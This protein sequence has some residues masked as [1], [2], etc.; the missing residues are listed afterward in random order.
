MRRCRICRADLTCGL[1]CR[2]QYVLCAHPISLPAL[3]EQPPQRVQ[4]GR[5]DVDTRG[6]QI[7]TADH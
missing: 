1:S 4:A 6:V 7:N 5:R 2:S 3:W